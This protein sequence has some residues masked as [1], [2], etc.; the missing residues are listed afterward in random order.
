MK[1]IHKMS[2]RA[3]ILSAFAVVISLML[4]VSGVVGS[5]IKTSNTNYTNLLENDGMSQGYL[6]EALASFCLIDEYLHDAV[7]FEDEEMAQDAIAE[8]NVYKAEFE[9]YMALAKPLMLEQNAI[10]VDENGET[11]YVNEVELF[12]KTMTYY[13]AYCDAINDI[14]AEIGSIDE[15]EIQK[16]LV[17]KIDPVYD[18]LYDGIFELTTVKQQAS[19]Y[20]I[21]AALKRSQATQY[22]LY[23][24]VG[25]VCIISVVTAISLSFLIAKPL[26]NCS[27]R[28]EKLAEGDLTSEVPFVKSKDETGLVYDATLKLKN[29]FQNMI[30]D[31]SNLLNEIA[32]GNLN[33]ESSCPEAYIGDFKPLLN[34]LERI[35]IDLTDTINQIYQ[36]A[37]QV[38]GG[39]DQ[40][41]SGAQALSQGSTE[42]ASSVEELSA[43]IIEISEHI[44]ANARN[45][46][47]ATDEAN[48]ASESINESN[49][50]MKNMI[51]AMNDI[52]N[53][54]NEISKIIKTIDDIAFQT[55]IL[56]LN[57][58]VEAAR[59]GAAGKGFAVVADEVRN[60]AQKS[61]EAAQN[62]TALIE[63]AIDAIDNGTKIADETATSLVQ[64]V[65][66]VNAVSEKI[67]EIANASE[68]QATAVS[69]LKVGIEQIS[70]VVQTNSATSEE[71]ASA[72]E[73]LSSQAQ[74]LKQII[75]KFKLKDVSNIAET[76][77]FVKDN[78]Y[79]D[80]KPKINSDTN[81]D[82]SSLDDKY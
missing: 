44:N 54:S 40:V 52:T 70:A 3:K 2:I 49:E 1:F 53:T 59:A 82:F 34:S 60:L 50:Q 29:N 15:V 26:R 25:L 68:E 51:S 47:E 55:N 9:S 21:A 24:F 32:Q 14:T 57:A 80:D 4:T 23:G 37:D 16:Q 77:L 73:E 72:A 43:T 65:E 36:G 22:F 11:I 56:A 6:G 8:I 45:S 74:M 30:S 38:A 61:A 66:K 69:Q 81:F 39:S 71:S 31:Q 5:A 75:G 67:N 42:Q 58:A 79:T 41:A 46:V 64:V 35:V 27:A 62:T 19:E 7:S 63:N 10:G 78:I 20:G 18:P 13:N 48:I 33:V 17:E 76:S 28:L 12:E